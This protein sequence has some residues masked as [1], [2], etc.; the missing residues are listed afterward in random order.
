MVCPIRVRVRVN[1][2]RYDCLLQLV[3]LES[4]VHEA[5]IQKQHATAIFFDL[6]KAYDT[7]WKFGI[8]KDL[9]NTGL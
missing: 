1:P 6:E 7:T 5:F 8:M 2:I 4:F 9:H 3:C